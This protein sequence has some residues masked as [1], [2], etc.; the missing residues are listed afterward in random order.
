[1]SGVML[2]KLSDTV[3]DLTGGNDPDLV[4][5][6]PPPGNMRVMRGLLI[7][8]S[9]SNGIDA[10]VSLVWTG[11]TILFTRW[12]QWGQANGLYARTGN[13]NNQT[14]L[15]ILSTEPS[16]IAMNFSFQTISPQ[17]STET[18][19]LNIQ[20]QNAVVSPAEVMLKAGSWVEAVDFDLRL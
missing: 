14:P 17:P 7:F 13:A 1:M 4:V 10:N 12:S 2:R 8:E 9:A 16:T 15:P 19:S 6:F 18:L 20:A 11:S 5:A 3:F